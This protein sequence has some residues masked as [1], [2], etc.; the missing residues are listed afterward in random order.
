[1]GEIRQD[2]DSCDSNNSGVVSQIPCRHHKRYQKGIILPPKARRAFYGKNLWMLK[3]IYHIGTY[4]DSAKVK[5][6]EQKMIVK[7]IIKQHVSKS[8]YSLKSSATMTRISYMEMHDSIMLISKC[9][10][11]LSN[12]YNVS[13][14]LL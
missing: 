6:S 8:F 12:N 2:L 10:K 4:V 5:S 11:K 13:G 3:L 7:T 9:R 1:M 14:S